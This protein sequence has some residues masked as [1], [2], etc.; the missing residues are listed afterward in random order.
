MHRKEN[1]LEI[2]HEKNEIHKYKWVKW[3]VANDLDILL[4]QEE[5]KNRHLDVRIFRGAGGGVSTNT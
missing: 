3:M 1:Q 4:V 5:N 2:F